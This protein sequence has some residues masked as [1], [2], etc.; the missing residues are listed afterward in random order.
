MHTPKIYENSKCKRKPY[1]WALLFACEFYMRLTEMDFNVELATIPVEVLHFNS[2]EITC[3]LSGLKLLSV[4]SN[5]FPFLWAPFNLSDYVMR[6]W[7]RHNILVWMSFE[8]TVQ[9]S[10]WKENISR[11]N[12]QFERMRKYAR[13]WFY[14]LWMCPNVWI[15]VLPNERKKQFLKFDSIVCFI[16]WPDDRTD[17]L[18][19]IQF[20]CRIFRSLLLANQFWSVPRPN[21]DSQSPGCCCIHITFLCAVAVKRHTMSISLRWQ[22]IWLHFHQVYLIWV[23]WLDSSY[24]R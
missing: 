11:A 19:T 16:L 7:F 23:I 9:N 14:A 13:R 18:Y 22:Q 1:E 12:V 10:E 17:E 24:R 8:F 5:L 15:D 21:S 20:A 6:H 3:T 2:I 4:D